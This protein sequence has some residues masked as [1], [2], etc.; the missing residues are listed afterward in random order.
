MCQNSKR[1]PR[2]DA[3]FTQTAKKKFTL[4]SIDEIISILVGHK[5]STKLATLH[6]LKANRFEPRKENWSSPSF[7]LSSLPPSFRLWWCCPRGKGQKGR[8]A[9]LC[10]H[11]KCMRHAGVRARAQSVSPFPFGSISH[12][13]L[14][15]LNMK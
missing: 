11:Q 9:F 8:A 2:R 15:R 12:R 5:R 13:V 1:R 7:T 10:T 14:H 3:G 4:L 6:L